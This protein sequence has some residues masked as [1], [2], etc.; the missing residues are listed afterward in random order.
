GR[1]QPRIERHPDVVA[2]G[3]R[4]TPLRQPIAQRPGK[5]PDRA[6][7]RTVW[8]RPGSSARGEEHIVVVAGTRAERERQQ[9]LHVADT[10]AEQTAVRPVRP[11][12][13]RERRR[14]NRRSQPDDEENQGLAHV[15]FSG[16]M[17]VS[18]TR[19]T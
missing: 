5:G 8:R 2:G 17:I 10:A 18:P 9:L 19:S 13:L 4:H 11:R 6:R 12:R 15:Y 7:R 14:C 1:I 16:T 3:E